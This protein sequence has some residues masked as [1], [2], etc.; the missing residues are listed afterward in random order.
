MS[1]E[2]YL[3]ANPRNIPE[4]L[5]PTVPNWDVL[6]SLL[7]DEDVNLRRTISAKLADDTAF[8]GPARIKLLRDTLAL[9]LDSKV[10]CNELKAL[11][12]TTMDA[13]ALFAPLTL[14]VYLEDPLVQ[15]SA[16]KTMRDLLENSP[17]VRTYVRTCLVLFAIVAGAHRNNQVRDELNNFLEA[18]EPGAGRHFSAMQ[19]YFASM[20]PEMRRAELQVFESSELNEIERAR[21]A[22]QALSPALQAK[23]DLL[24]LA[25]FTD[26]SEKVVKKARCTLYLS[27]ELYPFLAFGDCLKFCLNKIVPMQEQ[28]RQIMEFGAWGSAASDL[29]PG[30]HRLSVHA[31]HFAQ[32]FMAAHATA[33]VAGVVPD[34]MLELLCLPL[35]HNFKQEGA[36]EQSDAERMLREEFLQSYALLP[37]QTL[38]QSGAQIPRML[39]Q[40]TQD[41]YESAGVR[42]TAI[43]AI[44]KSE[45]M[46]NSNSGLIFE[47]LS[48]GRYAPLLRTAAARTL[49]KPDR[50]AFNT[51]E[52]MEKGAGIAAADPNRATSRVAGDALDALRREDTIWRS[53]ALEFRKGIELVLN[54]QNPA[55]LRTCAE[56]FAYTKEFPADLAR[57]RTA[58]LSGFASVVERMANTYRKIVIEGHGGLR[59]GTQTDRMRV[60]DQLEGE[61]AVRSGGEISAEHRAFASSLNRM[62]KVLGTA[63]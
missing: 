22:G 59:P 49:C 26:E 39:C 54:A 63:R 35:E 51:W 50:L 28:A 30:L 29:L 58:E 27:R 18:V 45:Y 17:E 34:H 53:I 57:W 15:L 10:L 3:P 1:L 11:S 14:M 5:E 20:F 33:R 8:Q 21:T 42:S 46:I 37:P 4:K 13:C 6:G 24:L 38:R 47:V 36:D 61:L 48:S 16:V 32:R 62:R 31:P 12:R 9:E 40:T 7:S 56:R 41:A 60:L 23:V 44:A 2:P 43:A 55:G 19:R 25:S 52:S